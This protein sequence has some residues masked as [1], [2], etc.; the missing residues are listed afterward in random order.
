MR[1]AW[2]K[3]RALFAESGLF[4]PDWYLAHSPD[5]ERAGRDPL[6]HFAEHGA[7]EGRD[8]G[9]G[10]E[11]AYYAEQNPSFAETGLSA[12]E[13][14]LR[15]GR[16]AGLEPMRPAPRKDT[17]LRDLVEQ[18]GFFDGEWYLTRYQDVRRFGQA[19][20]E[21]FIAAGLR[22]GRDPGPDFDTGFYVEENPSFAETELSPFEHY[23]RHGQELK[24]PTTRDRMRQGG[25]FAS[26]LQE[27]GLFDAE[28]YLKRNPD[29]RKFG[30]DPFDHLVRAGAREGRDPGP[31][32]DSAFYVEQNPAFP[33]DGSI[34]PLEH[35]LRFGRAAGIVPVGAP[36][37]VRWIDRFAAL[38]ELDI[39]RIEADAEA[40]PMPATHWVHIVR[41]E[42][43]ADRIRAAVAGQI[44]PRPALG[45]VR[46]GGDLAG[47]ARALAALP[48]GAVVI[49]SAGDVRVSGHAAYCFAAALSR[50]PADAAYCDHDHET[51]DG[52]RCRPVFKPEMS[53]TFMAQMPYAGPVV[54]VRLSAETRGWVQSA[55]A[56]AIDADPEFAFAALLLRHDRRSVKRLP[57]LLYT[58]PDDMPPDAGDLRRIL[59][60]IPASVKPLP[61]PR[62]ADPPRVS[63]LIPTRDRRELLEDCVSS[64]LA[65]TRYPHDR[66]RIV[67][68]DN[69]SRED[70][71]VSYLATLADHP[72]CQVVP[73]PGP[74]N[75]SKICNDGAAASDGDILLFLNNDITVIEPDWLTMLAAYAVAPDAGAIGAKLLYPDDTVQHAGVVLGLLGVGAHRFVGVERDECEPLDATREMT[76]VTGACLA[77]SRRAFEA[78]GGFDPI[79]AVAFNDAALCMRL[80]EAGYRNVYIA[81]PL[82]Y[83]HES[84][85]RGYD[86]SRQKQALN[87]REAIYVRMRHAPIFRDDPSYSPNL[88]LQRIGDL[89][90]PPRYMLPWRRSPQ[91]RVLLLSSVHGLGHGVASVIGLQ[92]E[93]FLKRGW[94]VAVGGMVGDRDRDYPG[95]RRVRLVTEVQAAA[96]AVAEGYDCV[97][98]HT[99]PFFSLARYLGSRPL[100]YIYDHGEPPPGLF[101]N[102][103]AREL[104]DWEKR[105]CAPLAQR[106]FTISETINQDQ[107]RTD[108]QVLRNGNTHL[109]TWTPDWAARR[110]ALRRKFGFEGR[111]VILNVCRFHESERRYKGVDLFADLAAESRYLVPHLAE[112]GAFVLVGRGD[113]E[114]V[115]YLRKAGLT[116]FPNVTDEEMAELYA[117]SDLY[118][119]L[120]QWE[121]YNLGIGQALAM[122]LPVVASDIPAHR[123][124]GIPTSNAVPRLC[125][126]V[127]EALSR[128]DEAAE[129]RIARLEP[130][131]VPLSKLVDALEEDVAA[132]RL[133]RWL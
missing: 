95:C 2:R 115:E 65:K 71:A 24:L 88:S 73:S 43:D 51:A 74:F 133:G 26:L 81:Q 105:F 101:E 21:H 16:D 12:F 9:P 127:G 130:W 11:A 77:V 15:H 1:D 13:H 94:D 8:P 103:E 54:A 78:V 83:H 57:L 122:G 64:I 34:S 42:T 35:Y 102:C 91:R 39:A 32:F 28:W 45:V 96:F 19:P 31:N 6:D 55:V 124:F 27:S 109:S 60:V 90:V 36:P 110:Q 53:P 44:G 123:E 50:G 97:I 89:G 30:A 33:N 48:D 38:T 14:Y 70:D 47:A 29:V 112:R 52:E 37:Y 22:E 3:R 46:D 131:D 49:L 113:E 129:N 18:S 108:A 63:I 69:D 119:S 59:E 5:L 121:G 84:K 125:A 25:L 117:A 67:V 75:F 40:H 61:A 128:C 68:I 72:S 76:A 98:A 80:Y 116:V 92:A 126:L 85:S 99:P 56:Q 87:R 41:R 100:F 20:L 114:D 86:D 132:D 10:F 120:S 7:R 107:Y 111:S 118:M 66:F 62:L 23:L 104:L 17:E 82:L 93:Y 106:V 4:D 58:L 79:L